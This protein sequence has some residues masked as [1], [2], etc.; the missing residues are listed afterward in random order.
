MSTDDANA[1]GGQVA[2]IIA[3]QPRASTFTPAVALALFI[4]DRR[5]LTSIDQLA[6]IERRQMTRMWQGV[7]LAELIAKGT[8]DD[9]GDDF[10]L[11]LEVATVVDDSGTIRY[12]IYGNNYGGMY[13]MEADR[14]ECVAFASQHD[15]ERWH[16]SQRDLFWAMDRAMR[17]G[18]H[19]FQQPISFDWWGDSRW[20]EIAGKPPGTMYSAPYILK[21]FSGDD[22]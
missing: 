3:A 19:G 17:R 4:K 20:S 8:M 15:V 10:P 16:T 1:Y 6:P 11:D 2:D 12:R 5:A 22:P 14:L 7:D 18:D 13:L 21:T 9:E